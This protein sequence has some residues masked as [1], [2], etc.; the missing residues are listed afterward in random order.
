MYTRFTPPPPK[1]P[2]EDCILTVR[3]STF[4]GEVIVVFWYRTVFERLL[5]VTEIK[6]N[7]G[8]MTF[9]LI[10]T[11]NT[12]FIFSHRITERPRRVDNFY[13]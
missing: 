11:Q 6:K 13:R 1:K 8:L 4:E 3:F 9:N 12:C 10:D 5:K 7:T 2:N